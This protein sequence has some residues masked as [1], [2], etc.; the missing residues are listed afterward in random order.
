MN[1]V[2][3]LEA[4]EECQSCVRL[5][6]QSIDGI[7]ELRDIHYDLKGFLREIEILRCENEKKVETVG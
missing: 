6:I 5:A 7:Y 4:L 2:E 1:N 3:L